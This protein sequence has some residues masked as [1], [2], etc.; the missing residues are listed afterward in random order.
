MSE[1]TEQL[2]NLLRQDIVDLDT[3]KKLLDQE[4]QTLTTRNTDQISLLSKHKTQTVQQ[5]ESRGK[6]K[7]R[8]IAESGLRIKPGHVEEKLQTLN[9]DDLVNLWQTSREKMQQCKD[10]NQVNGSIISRSLQRTNKLMTIIR[11]QNKTQNLYGQQ[12][13]EQSYGST[14]RIGQA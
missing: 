7:A 9:D 14:H 3:L 8:L 12:G 5:L 2:K 13:K 10:T 11:G 6:I 1:F 4:K